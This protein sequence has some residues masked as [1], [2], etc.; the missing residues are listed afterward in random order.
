MKGNSKNTFSNAKESLKWVKSE[1]ID[2]FILLTNNYHMP[3]AMLEFKN[4]FNDFEI[5]PYVLIDKDNKSINQFIN[6]ISEYVKYN[7]ALTR[8]NFYDFKSSGKC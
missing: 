1:N 3:R 6:F 5:K 2:S 7:L 4:V 8:L